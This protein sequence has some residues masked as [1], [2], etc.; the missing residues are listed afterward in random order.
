M[1]C[2]FLNKLSAPYVRNYGSSLMK[3]YSQFCPVMSAVNKM[4]ISAKDPSSLNKDLTE[5]KCP[6]LAE[7]Q[8]DKHLVTEASN[9]TQEDVISLHVER[10]KMF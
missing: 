1:H 6:F 2:P 10:G 8:N 7:V 5:K 4:H 9:E 3:M